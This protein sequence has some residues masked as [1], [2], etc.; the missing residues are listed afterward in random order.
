[1]IRDAVRLRAALGGTDLAWIVT[2]ARR[3]MSQGQPLDGAISLAAPN[4]SQRAALDGLLG[5]APSAGDSL[6]VRLADVES[7]LQRAE[8]CDRLADAVEALA[9][10]VRDER[11]DHAARSARWEALFHDAERSVGASGPLLAWIA[12]IRAE[13]LLRRLSGGDVRAARTLFERAV[14]VAKR[15][16]AAGVPLAEFAAA[17]AG[18]SHALDSGAPLGTLV[19]RAAAQIA[20][21]G[22]G[23]G[24]EARRDGW[25]RVG[26]LCDEL[27]APVLVLNLRAEETSTTGRALAL[28]ANA[29]EPY[30][31]SL[32][33]LLR[34][35]PVFDLCRTGP[36]VRLCENPTVVAAAAARLG[37][38]SAP[39]VCV[40]GQPKTAAHVL[41]R[42]LRAAGVRLACHGDFDWG[43]IR[44]ANV[45]VAR[46]GA[47]PWRFGA[48]DYAA[49]C[50][51]GAVRGSPLR[52]PPAIASWDADL[53]PAMA[54]AARAVH[55]EQV[56]GPLLEDLAAPRN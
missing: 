39:L 28:H 45:L 12:E 9:G 18:D 26:V 22:E 54:S 35:R 1:M 8:I 17:G 21:A 19:L 25:A 29:G 38:S 47:V 48:A 24:A 41:L 53:A 20:G 7:V 51:S 14:E 50:G 16:P 2:R 34:D 44:I 52:G 49:A 40:E 3:R 5:R 10:P 37:R 32:R 43:G 23:E 6:T 56:L 31:V 13:G 33:Q 11:A 46:H 15:L 4:A 55:E 30:R 36:E 42:A 27:S